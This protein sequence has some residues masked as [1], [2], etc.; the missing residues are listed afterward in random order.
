MKDRQDV[1]D[2]PVAPEIRY[3][4]RKWD[5]A[6]Q[7]VLATPPVS[8]HRKEAG[9]AVSGSLDPLGRSHPPRPF[10]GLP[11]SV[12]PGLNGHGE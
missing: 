1:K 9:P 5:P 4:P 8:A 7:F 12:I 6:R 3:L 11:L 10:R 2:H